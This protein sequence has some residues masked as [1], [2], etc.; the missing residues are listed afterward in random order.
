LRR[1]IDALL[2]QTEP[3]IARA[4]GLPPMVESSGLR[5]ETAVIVSLAERLAR[6]LRRGDPLAARVKL[7]RGDFA[8]ALLS[9]L[10]RARK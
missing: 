2:D 5:R 9:G 7:T 1:V 4:R 3:L 10:W 6:R 8:L